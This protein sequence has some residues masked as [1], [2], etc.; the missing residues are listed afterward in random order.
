MEYDSLDYV[1]DNW[2]KK[3]KREHAVALFYNLLYLRRNMT[4][5]INVSDN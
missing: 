4:P 5:R 3:E 1:S 2:K